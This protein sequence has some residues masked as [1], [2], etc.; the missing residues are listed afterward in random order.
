MIPYLYHLEYDVVIQAPSKEDADG[1]A[2]SVSLDM[3]V[4]VRT[5]MIQYRGVDR[6]EE[7]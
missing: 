5:S 3:G 7:E 4:D 1:I 2:R 6:S